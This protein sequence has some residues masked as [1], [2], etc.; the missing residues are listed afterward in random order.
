VDNTTSVALARK[1]SDL[2]FRQEISN[3]DAVLSDFV[4]KGERSCQLQEDV[5]R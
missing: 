2:D 5:G 3:N 4:R 1:S